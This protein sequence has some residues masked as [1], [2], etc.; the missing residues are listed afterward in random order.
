MEG[1]QRALFSEFAVTTIPLVHVGGINS[2]AISAS[3]GTK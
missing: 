1:L 3:S 2:N